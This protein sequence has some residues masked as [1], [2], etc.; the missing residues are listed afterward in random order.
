MIALSSDVLFEV[1]S[2]LKRSE[3]GELAWASRQLN[4]FTKKHFPNFPLNSVDCLLIRN[5]AR[6]EHYFAFF[7]N[8]TTWPC[9]Q[10]ETLQGYA[11]TQ[12]FVVKT[13][14]LSM[15]MQ[16]LS[17]QWKQKLESISALWK[18]GKLVLEMERN[19]GGDEYEMLVE[20][21]QLCLIRAPVL[22]RTADLP[23]SRAT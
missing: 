22:F 16:M 3:L 6:P 21:F 23:T 5:C 20:V 8:S 9:R 13:A 14:I 10:L 15:S 11:S 12:R 18:S 2:F 17:E 7:N 19:H 4:L 1:L